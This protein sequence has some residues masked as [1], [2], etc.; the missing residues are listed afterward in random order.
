MELE[1]KKENLDIYEPGELQTL[2][3]EETA[4]T[5]VPDYCPDIA[6]IISVEGSVYLRSAETEQAD[7]SGSVR[8]CVLYMPEGESG[9]RTLEFSMPFTAQ[10]GGNGR[11][12]PPGG[13]DGAGTAGEPDAEPQKALYPLQAGDTV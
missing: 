1:L 11:S 13:G 12:V 6:R 2:T 3:Q 9:V 4:E 8:V 10:G 5:I 7:V